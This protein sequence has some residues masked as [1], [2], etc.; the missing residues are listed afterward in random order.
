MSNIRFA[1][2]ILLASATSA[3]GQIY[4][5]STFAGSV[6]PENLPATSISLGNVAD[7]TSDS[8]G[9]IFLAVLSSAA[10]FRV[11]AKTGILTRV[12]GNGTAGFSGD[13]G[14]AVAAQLSGP[15]SAMAV[16]LAGNLYI[17]D[18]LRV[19]Q[20]TNGVIGT[21][22]GT[23][24]DGSSGDG[25]PALSAQL[26]DL[27]GL[28]TDAAGSLYLLVGS[29]VRKIAN[30]IITSVPGA[31]GTYWEG[32]T[33]DPAGNLYLVGDQVVKLADGTVTVLAG[34]GIS[35]FFGDNGPATSA[36]LGEDP[37]VC[38]VQ[39]I[40][41]DSAGNVYIADGCNDRIRKVSNGIITTVAGGGA[42]PAAN[43]SPATAIQL[44]QPNLIAV[45][46]AG[47]LYIAQE[48]DQGA[49]VLKVV[50]GLAT[51]IA[52]NGA[53]S[54]S[55]D[56]GPAGSAQFDNPSGVAV[57]ATGR[58]YIADAAN[59]R[60]RMI[61]N[62]IVTTI[63]GTGSP[64]L[65]GDDGP[66]VNAQ[67]S[68]PGA[69][70]LNPAGDLFIAD[71][72]N[73]RV[74][75]VSQGVIT[76]VNGTIGYDPCSVAADSAGNVYV[77]DCRTHQIL[78]VS[79]GTAATIAG[80][81]AALSSGENVPATSAGIAWVNEMAVDSS[82]NLYLSD[83]G[84][85]RKVSNGV[86]TTITGGT[87]VTLDA[88]GNLYVADG[89][90]NLIRTLSGGVAAFPTNPPTQLQQLGGHGYLG[91]LGYAIAADS[92]GNIYGSDG[93]RIVVLKS[94]G[95][96]SPPTS[97]AVDFIN[98]AASNSFAGIAPGEIVTLSG[99]GLGP[100]KLVS[101]QPG[102]N[103]FYATQLAGTIVQFNGVAAPLIYTSATQ[104]SAVAPYGVS[105]ADTQVTV[106]YNGQ[107]SVPA[108]V[109]VLPLATGVFTLDGS[110]VG[111]AAVINQDGTLNNAS[112][113]APIGSVVSFFITGGGQTSP[114][115]V[116]GQVATLPLPRQ[117]IPLT[118]Q[119]G[120]S[121]VSD[122]YYLQYVGAAPGEIAGL[123]QIN[124]LIPRGVTTGSAVSFGLNSSQQGVT[125]AV[126]ASGN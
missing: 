78:R 122:P 111:Q 27:H 116:D 57:D 6:V 4:I 46:S 90:L 73:A 115:G 77:F 30:G 80:N 14:P 7:L 9:N 22:A 93:T 49:P 13:G 28:A 70:A 19:R 119:I 83:S 15:P 63:A 121:L 41:A 104:V 107:T 29:D 43:N 64:A 91:L 65:G 66:A 12:A 97:S 68:L 53:R 37:G 23:G 56:G 62:G 1:T 48:F 94:D 102:D 117:V 81:G 103:G 99:T 100:S 55:G 123:T 3:F 126:S 18:N 54:F 39:G 110:G 21:V 60:V 112:H 17:A 86:I 108:T 11:D 88:V 72:N 87:G 109:E 118:V 67:L 59:N 84:R 52:G 42:S 71:V 31:A 101:A 96:I 45:D 113:P 79:N 47:N 5:G 40:A 2:A 58:V 20:V 51:E 125:I 124:F 10:V 50:N 35:G 95:S 25:G 8:S 74:R 33:V 105:G 98:N 26:S 82:G 92:V 106:T 85:I 75:K 120:E 44:D 16:D 32:L 76:T 34:N 38:G 24:V 69:L 89:N 61:S 36:G 114:G